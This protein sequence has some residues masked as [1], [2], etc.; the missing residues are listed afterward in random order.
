ML[1]DLSLSDSCE[2]RHEIRG[3]NLILFISNASSYIK[4]IKP[5]YKTYKILNLFYSASNLVSES[6][7]P[8]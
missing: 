2:G 8:S 7:D 5:Y 6:K 1:L 4:F 3:S